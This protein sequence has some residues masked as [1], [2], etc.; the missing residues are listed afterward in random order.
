MYFRDIYVIS[1]KYLS[2]KWLQY[3]LQNLHLHFDSVK[4]FVTHFLTPEV[5]NLNKHAAIYCSSPPQLPPRLRL[6]YQKRPPRPPP[7]STSAS[8]QQPPPQRQQRL[9]VAEANPNPSVSSAYSS[10]HKP[11]SRLRVQLQ[12][13]LPQLVGPSTSSSKGRLSPS[14]LRPSLSPRSSH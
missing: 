9:L 14:S 10:P 6:W 1:G 7:P 4:Y 11:S 3:S 13:Q 12:W 2:W 5:W 8:R